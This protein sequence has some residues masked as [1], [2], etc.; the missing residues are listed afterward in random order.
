M[1]LYQHSAKCPVALRTFLDCNP[2]YWCFIPL[3]WQE[4]EEENLNALQQSSDRTSCV[5]NV[6]TPPARAKFS[7]RQRKAQRVFFQNV[8]PLQARYRPYSRTDLHKFSIVAVR[9]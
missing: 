2:N 8:L 7:Y 3:R 5:D 1:R 6:P 9:K 4:A